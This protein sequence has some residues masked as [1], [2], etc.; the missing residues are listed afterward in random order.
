MW[1]G[2]VRRISHSW[3]PQNFKRIYLPESIYAGC[4]LF[5]YYFMP[6]TVVVP[7]RLSEPPLVQY[8]YHFP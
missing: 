8:P 2:A 5:Y 6:G 1:Q 3:L 7:H 4:D